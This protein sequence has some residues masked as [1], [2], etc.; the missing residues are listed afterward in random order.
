[1]AA[2][3]SFLR[4]VAAAV[5]FIDDNGNTSF[6]DDNGNTSFMDDNGVIG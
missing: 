5:G 1:M 2:V 6:I 4:L 3:F